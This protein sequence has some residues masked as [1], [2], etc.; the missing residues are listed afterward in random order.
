[1]AAQLLPLLVGAGIAVAVMG[2]KKKKKPT[3]KKPLEAGDDCTPST[4]VPA[5]LVCEAGVL[6][7]ASVSEDDLELDED[8]KGEDAGDFEEREEDMTDLEDEDPSEILDDDGEG[9]EIPVMQTEAPD[10]S[11]LCDEFLKAVHVK[12]NAPGEYPINDVAV[13]QTVIP[14]MDKTVKAF[15]N[16]QTPVQTEVAGPRMVLESLEALVPV[17]KWK[18]DELEDEFTFDDGRTIDSPEGQ[19]VLF[20]LMNMSV[21]IIEEFN[22]G[23][24]LQAT[25]DPQS[26]QTPNLTSHGP[27]TKGFTASESPESTPNLTSHG[28]ATKGFTA[29]ESPEST[30]NLTPQQGN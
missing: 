11:E 22:K 8:P 4:E 18:Y 23:N 20:G 30:P 27:A 5:G 15:G 1:M 10:P 19:E 3:K 16:V 21:K 28:P 25:L 9:Q 26:G 14:V 24:T 17:C 6:E 12:P 7:Q 13:T 29:S 2:G